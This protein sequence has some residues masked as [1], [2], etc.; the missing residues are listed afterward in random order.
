MLGP[1]IMI[2][3][4]KVLATEA[5]KILDEVFPSEPAASVPT[6]AAS[7]PT[8]AAREYSTSYGTFNLAGPSKYRMPERSGPPGT[9]PGGY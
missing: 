7:V 4:A 8:A 5:A 1:D 2:K 9:N 6:A 3:A